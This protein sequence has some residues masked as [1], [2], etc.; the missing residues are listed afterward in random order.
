MP[1]DWKT[2]KIHYERVPSIIIHHSIRFE[3]TYRILKHMSVFTVQAHN[4]F[5]K[6][7]GANPNFKIKKR[8]CSVCIVLHIV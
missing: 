4:I 7:N 2:I 5:G 6:Q 1:K 8:L 3:M